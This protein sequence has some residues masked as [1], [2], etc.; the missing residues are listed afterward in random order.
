M[1]YAFKHSYCMLGGWRK[2]SNFELFYLQMIHYY[3]EIKCYFIILGKY[4]V[5]NYTTAQRNKMAM[6]KNP[7]R[8]F[9]LVFL[10]LIKS[11]YKKLKH[12]LLV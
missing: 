7:N 10:V 8:Y 11:A 12:V 4:C 3:V 1:N 9:C 6:Q 2:P 5:E